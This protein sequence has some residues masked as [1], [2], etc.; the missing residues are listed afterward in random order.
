[1]K[2][3]QKTLIGG[4][5][6]LI[7]SILF[8]LFLPID[9]I[10]KGISSIP[11][12]GVLLSA[13]YHIIKDEIAHEKQIA[14]QK[15]RQFF[16]LAVTSH[17]ANTAFD[18]HVE[19]CE[20]Y[21]VEVHQTLIMLIQEGPTKSVLENANRMFKLRQDFSAWITEEIAVELDKFE[22]AVRSI[23][24]KTGLA[25]SLIS[26]PKEA[27]AGFKAHAEAQELFSN[28]LGTLY[29]NSQPID[30]DLAVEKVKAKI[31]DILGIEQLTKI[32]K[33]VIEQAVGSIDDGT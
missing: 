32:R 21:M 19:F 5:I 17:M 13:L 7:L 26:N 31:R 30:N 24:T 28:V 22:S 14:L 20:K 2:L 10:F 9:D 27:A 25:E 6:V 15:K 8:T 18:K 11:A 23:A 4:G 1:M 29:D 33:W 16:D 3:R 12:V